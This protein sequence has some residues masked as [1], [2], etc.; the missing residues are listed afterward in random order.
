[1]GIN[2]PKSMTRLDKRDKDTVCP[3]KLALYNQDNKT[4]IFKGFAKTEECTDALCKV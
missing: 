4:N 2:K 3:I 1:M